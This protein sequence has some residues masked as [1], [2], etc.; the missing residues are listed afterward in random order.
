LIAQAVAAQTACAWLADLRTASD[1]DGPESAVTAANAI[2][3]L[4]QWDE[5]AAIP[6]TIIGTGALTLTGRI[7]HLD[8]ALEEVRSFDLEDPDANFGDLDINATVDAI[9]EQPG[10]ELGCPAA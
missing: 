5:L 6:D 7:R 10:V 8:A 3:D 4:A 1:S 9:L 2:H